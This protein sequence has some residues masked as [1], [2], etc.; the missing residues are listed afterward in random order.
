MVTVGSAQT[1]AEYNTAMNINNTLNSQ[2]AGPSS[3][4]FA[5]PAGQRPPAPTYG[6]PAYGQPAYGQ[7]AYGQP[8][9]GQPAYGQPAYGQPAYGQ[10]GYGQP[11]YGQPAYGQP[12]YGVPGAVPG[13]FGQP[14]VPAAP[15][16]APPPPV[17][18]ILVLT[19]VRVTDAWSGALLEDIHYEYRPE[20]EKGEFYDDGTHGDLQAGDNI[21][22]NYSEDNHVLSP[23]SNR[24]KLIYLRMLSLGEDTNPLEF[25]R[26]PVATEEPLSNL[27]RLSDQEKDRDETFLRQWQR[28]FLSRY[29]QDENDPTSDF[30]PIFVP[31]PPR[32]PETP[33]PPEN[34][35]NQNAFLLDSYIQAA[36][37]QATAPATEQAAGPGDQYN[38]GT[39]P[40][41]RSSGQSSGYTAR[42]SGYTGGAAYGDRW[43]QLRQDAARYGSAY[44]TYQSSSY[45]RR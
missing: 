2:S 44:G 11:G 45:F 23:E 1:L 20:T 4:Y 30:Y 36:V 7:P 34:Q 18:Q 42:S 19:G 37:S 14:A 28:Q 38:Q 39:P 5:P 41:R 13:A 8:A 27:P 12:G 33:A 25:F 26:I 21:W 15:T 16:P 35:Y 17:K 3:Q 24:I 6:Q 31:N 9:Y 40:P 29:R 32:P 22:T 10:P 43:G